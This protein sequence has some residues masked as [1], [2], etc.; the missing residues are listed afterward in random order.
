MNNL[1]VLAVLCLMVGYSSQA[2]AQAAEI[3]PNNT[4]TG[5]QDIGSIDVTSPFTVTGSLDTPAGYTG[6]R[7]LQVR[8]HAGRFCGG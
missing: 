6:C 2:L 8:G 3:E 1:R 4:C 5:A 7:L